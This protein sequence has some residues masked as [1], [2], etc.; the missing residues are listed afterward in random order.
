MRDPARI[1]DAAL[2]ELRLGMSQ[3]NF[4]SYLAGTEASAFDDDELTILVQNPLVRETLEQR[5]RQHI[6]RALFDVVGRPCRVRLTS[7]NVRS[8][9]GADSY[10]MFALAGE[11]E[12]GSSRSNGRRGGRTA[13]VEPPATAGWEGSP[14][15]Q[16]YTFERFVVGSANRL[17]HA[18]SQA[19]AD[20]PGQAYNPLFL[21]LSLI[22]ISEPTRPY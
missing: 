2:G 21:Y 5:F 13:V 14:L 18:A 17:A 6:L 19:V 12:G 4:E 10:G 3:A 15:N 8:T 7:G 11:R 22:H 9:N 20:A 1:W 16:R